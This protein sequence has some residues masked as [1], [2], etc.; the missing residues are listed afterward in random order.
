MSEVRLKEK[1]FHKIIQE[2]S[3]KDNRALADR[4]RSTHPEL[5]R[6]ANACKGIPSKKSISK[7]IAIFAPLATVAV[8]AIFLIPTLLVYTGNTTGSGDSSNIG[9]TPAPSHKYET[10]ELNCTVKEYNE[11]YNTNFLYFDFIDV[12][13]YAVTQYNSASSRVF[14]GLG[15]SL[16]NTKT[17]DDIEYYICS[18]ADSLGFLEYNIKICI[19]ESMILENSI[20]W[21]TAD[22]NSYGIFYY[23]GYGYYIT[24]KN[25]PNETRLFELIEILLLSQI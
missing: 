19:N 12:F 22:N 11:L 24:L 3:S 1:D 7:R 15:V 25:N 23:D 17:N 6:N 8:L 14:M 4:L 5:V 20:K 21:T 13:D 9:H 18:D 16:N 10:S 2:S